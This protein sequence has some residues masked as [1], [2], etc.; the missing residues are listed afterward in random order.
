MRPKPKSTAISPRRGSGNPRFFMELRIFGLRR[1]IQHK[2]KC[3][4]NHDPIPYTKANPPHDATLPQEAHRSGSAAQ[5]HQWLN[6]SRSKRACRMAIRR[7]ACSLLALP[8]FPEFAQEV[9][10]HVFRNSE[11]LDGEII[12]GGSTRAAQVR[13]PRQ[14][15]G[16]LGSSSS[17]GSSLSSPVGAASPE[18][19]RS[20]FSLR[21]AA[22]TCSS[23]IDGSQP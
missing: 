16:Y 21:R 12:G 3:D 6:A 15:C 10:Y 4:P 18:A 17:D 9:R 20:R 19:D 5:G 8:D 11:P 1:R 23:V 13:H 2:P 7:N 14:R 22:R